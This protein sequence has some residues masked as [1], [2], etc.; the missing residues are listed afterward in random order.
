MEYAPTTIPE[1]K[2]N[3]EP[4]KTKL[5]VVTS[6]LTVEEILAK[7]NDLFSGEI[8]FV[9]KSQAINEIAELLHPHDMV[10][11]GIVIDELVR[12]TKVGKKVWQDKVK[13]I[14]NENKGREYDEDGLP[15]HINH[16]DFVK[17][18]FYED[19]NKYF[20]RTQQGI[21]PLS[22]F[23]MRP[24]FH[25]IS[26]TNAKRLY[27]LTNE[28]G[29]SQ[30]IELNMDELTSLTAFNK[31]I[32]GKGNYLFE[33]ASQHLTKLKRMWYDNTKTCTEI[34]Q[35]GW[36]KAGFF[37]WA[38]GIYNG[39]FTGI[40]QYGIVEHEGE[41][42]YIPAF[43]KI[44]YHDK[45]L[46]INERKFRHIDDSKAELYLLTIK[47]KTV[48][49]DNG[50]IALAYALSSIFRDVIIRQTGNFPIL[51]LFGPKG[52]GKTYLARAIMA[53]FGKDELLINLNNSTIPALSD[54]VAASANSLRGIDEYKNSA[55]FQK[56]EFLKG[57][58][59]SVGR[60]RMN[61]EK[62]KK[63]EMTSVDAGI[64][65]CGQDM[66]TADNALFSRLIFCRFHKSEFNNN[67]KQAFDDLLHYFRAGITNIT[68]QILSHRAWFEEN[69]HIS[70]DTVFRDMKSVFEKLNVEE[71]I[72][73]SYTM[74]LAAWNCISE[75]VN[76]GVN[77]P[78]IKRVFIEFLKI[79]NSHTASSNEISVF[80]NIF[81]YLYKDGLIK[82][83]V[84]FKVKSFTTIK[85][86]DKDHKEITRNFAEG[87]LLLL[88]NH[89][90]IIPLYRKHGQQMKENVLP[91][92]TLKHY[93]LHNKAY[94]GTK[95]SEA[96]LIENESQDTDGRK[97]YNT[98]N[99][100][101]F[102]YE[103]LGI[104]VKTDKYLETEVDVL[105]NEN[106]K[107]IP[108]V[109]EGVLPF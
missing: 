73:R 37:T 38:N 63:R 91:V 80:W 16:R 97:P 89:S 15:E 56:I 101:A 82:H 12:L 88:M 6:I 96:F 5:T 11:R 45:S 2:P 49:G 77:Y 108:D 23:V 71:R 72:L 75:K 76:T 26:I 87:R 52:T 35:M 62:D 81:E 60:N 64:I 61:M 104:E 46:F 7:A 24:L 100:M 39:K 70:Y 57:L 102:D 50:V 58:Y 30:V 65:L 21:L 93:L 9:M 22:N 17:Y 19:Q 3:T 31:H 41:N 79:Q 43:S 8:D 25:V 78:D 92:D 47:L 105:E 40:D 10:M 66:P 54:H 98:T 36:H 59:D 85:L 20:F 53:L 84:D 86:V 83:R 74:I 34:V 51:N 13:I 67:E 27:E 68:N 14:D 107:P 55:D 33:G 44:Y 99:C 18:G 42:Y 103:T 4:A 109:K 28:Y 1:T 69:Y 29:D 94:L 106:L 95:K 90:R 48:Y 32:E